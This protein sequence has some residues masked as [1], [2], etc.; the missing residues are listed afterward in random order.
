MGLNYYWC[1][2]KG[3]LRLQDQDG[4]AI[5]RSFGLA[6]F[7]IEVLYDLLSKVFSVQEEYETLDS[8]SSYVSIV[9][10]HFPV[11]YNDSFFVLMSL[12][13]WSKIM[14]VLKE[15]K[16]RRGGKGLK[17]ILSFRGLSEELNATILFSLQSGKGLWEFNN[18][19][20][21]I[22]YLVDVIPLQVQDLIGKVEKIVYVYDESSYKWVPQLSR[23]NVDVP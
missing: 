22:E 2:H 17:I 16:R 5:M 8:N 19:I 3:T 9:E 13:R 6:P 7:E 10:I 12:D 18:A 14:D 11:P 4:I 20:E 23:Q 1:S 21:K 15:M